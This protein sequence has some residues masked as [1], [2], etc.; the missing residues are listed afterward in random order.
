MIEIKIATKTDAE[1][2]TLL[3]RI[4]YTESHG[5]FIENKNDLLTYN[6]EEFSIKKTNEDLAN[7]NILLYIMYVDKLPVGYAKLVLN[8]ANI[9]V[10]SK[11]TCR[12]EKIYILQDFIPLKVGQQFF[13]FINEVAKKLQ[14]QTIWLTVYIK[15]SRAIGFYQKNEFKNVG[16][17]NFNIN[18]KDYENSIFLKKI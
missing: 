3:G 10:P 1:I 6:N 8:A 15:N 17:Y 14:F 12:L 16:T 2:L 11:Q 18:G 5:H 9:N 4:T 13:D 7:K